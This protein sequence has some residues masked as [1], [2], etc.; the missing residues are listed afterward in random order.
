MR[1]DLFCRVIDNFGDAGVAWRLARQLQAEQ[2]ADV[3]LILDDIATLARLDHRVSPD[4]DVQ[5]VGD[6]TVVRWGGAL[7]AVADVVVETFA[8]EAPAEYVEAMAERSPA[9]AWINLEYLSAED[10][11]GRCHRLPSPHPRHALT[12]H[13]FF[14]GFGP[15]TGGLLREQGLLAARDAFRDDPAARNRFW[16]ELSLSAPAAEERVVSL[17]GYD[18]VQV[19]DL[20]DVWTASAQPVRCLIPDGTP[21]ALRAAHHARRASDSHS[22]ML[23]SLT[24]A[25]IPFRDQVDYD[26]LLWVADFNFVRGEDSFVRAQWA[27]KPMAWH[28]YPQSGDAHRIKL[29]AF[30]EKYLAGLEPPIAQRVHDLFLAWNGEGHLGEAWNALSGDWPLWATHAR[31]WAGRLAAAPDLVS[32]LADFVQKLL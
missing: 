11:V 13:F 3:R 14:P 26:P 5:T 25:W 22:A 24:L 31:L 9:P 1:W 29:E 28:I 20:F 21:L 19:H 6:I 8:C 4:A 12:R 27:A 2:G 16:R 30:L 15:E 32:N 7:G 17:F 10:W 23:G 18:T